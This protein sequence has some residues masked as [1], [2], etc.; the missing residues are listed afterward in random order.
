MACPITDDAL[1]VVAKHCLEVRTLAVTSSSRVTDASLSLFHDECAIERV[2]PP[3][4]SPPPAPKKLASSPSS[5]KSVKIEEVR[6]VEAPEVWV[7]TSTKGGCGGCV[8]L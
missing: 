1:K 8:V 2:A 4:P 3:V 7:D 5:L 6:A